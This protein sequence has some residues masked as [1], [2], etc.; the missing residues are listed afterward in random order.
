MCRLG[1][2]LTEFILAFLPLWSKLE[3]RGVC[4]LWRVLILSKQTQLLIRPKNFFVGAP[5]DTL[6]VGQH[7]PTKLSLP[8]G[9]RVMDARFFEVLLR[10][11][12]H[13]SVIHFHSLSYDIT[14][15][16][17]ILMAISSHCPHLKHISFGLMWGNHIDYWPQ[18]VS[19][20]KQRA[21]FRLGWNH[22][23]DNR[24]SAI[25]DDLTDLTVFSFYGLENNTVLPKLTR[26]RLSFYLSVDFSGSL[27][28]ILFLAPNLKQ[29]ELG[30]LTESDI[31]LFPC[32]ISL[33][34][35][36]FDTKL[37]PSELHRLSDRVPNLKS[38]TVNFHRLH[39]RNFS[40][41]HF[42]TFYSLRYL[43]IKV[44]RPRGSSVSD[45]GMISLVS[46]YPR[47][48]TLKIG[49]ETN[50]TA[51]F[52][53]HLIVIAKNIR[54][55]FLNPRSSLSESQILFSCPGLKYTSIVRLLSPPDNLSFCFW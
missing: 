51:T 10:L 2:D 54:Y 30:D 49:F 38:L 48:N 4:R 11:C 9:L 8:S 26:L 25:I 13:I 21:G 16:N 42:P 27:G 32:L 5:R 18:F 3:L 15:T 52:F 17:D 7:I 41:R 22:V 6:I 29:L 28:R 44:T 53:Q 35:L 12:P 1:P 50:L 19:H 39:I 37:F 45:D 31:N 36:M 33:E 23:G 55:N 43:L 46:K 24:V 40:L 47:L 14:I 20:F 34:V